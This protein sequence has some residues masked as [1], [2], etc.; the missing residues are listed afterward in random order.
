MAKKMYIP[1]NSNGRN[2]K[3]FMDDIVK[4]HSINKSRRPRVPSYNA[5]DSSPKFEALTDI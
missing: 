4:V 1:V 3:L 5:T 2:Y